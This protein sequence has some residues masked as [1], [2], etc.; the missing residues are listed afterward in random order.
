MKSY[1]VVAIIVLA[2]LLVGV[3][4]FAKN[5]TASQPPVLQNTI[6]VTV[7]FYPLYYFTSQI[8][9]SLVNITNLTPAG[10]EPH[11]YEPNAQD[12]A[13]LQKSKLLIVNGN[14]EPW[15][16]KVKGNFDGEHPKILEVGAGLTTLSS[17]ENGVKIPD[18]HIWLDPVLTQLVVKNITKSLI[19]VDPDHKQEYTKNS[20]ELLKKL[21]EL[22][23]EYTTGLSNCKQKN[24]VTSHQ[25][26]SYIA[27]RY[28][29]IQVSIAGLSP[30]Q[31][32]SPA[33]LAKVAEFVKTH[34]IKYIFF[35]SLISSRLADTIAQE[36]GA[37]TLVFDPIEGVSAADQSAGK[38]YFSIQRQNL[39]NLRIALECQ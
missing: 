20:Q 19:D 36:T 34:H 4:Y 14:L 3:A 31:E 6:P 8:G 15:F 13:Q 22:N 7:S 37:Q 5:R 12:I 11:D 1:L 25:A 2:G 16:D 18:P 28:S 33:E 24:V 32:P 21:A 38:D 9:G 27:A 29:L 26:F 30:D 35:E 39:S 10:A 23:Q 17:T